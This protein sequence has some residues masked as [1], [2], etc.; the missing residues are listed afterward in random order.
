M[1]VNQHLADVVVRASI[2]ATESRLK[3]YLMN[4][5]AQRR[6]GPAM[7]VDS[8][9]EWRK[10]VRGAILAIRSLEL[11]LLQAARYREMLH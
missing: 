6:M 11:L 9:R 1:K 2:V 4:L 8:K 5:N 7:Y 10:K 3:G